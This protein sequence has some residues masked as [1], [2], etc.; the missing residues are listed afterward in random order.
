MR[1]ILKFGGDAVK[2]Q[3]KQKKAL[4][5]FLK[6]HKNEQL[7]IEEIAEKMPEEL[8]KSTLYRLMGQMTEQGQVMR[9]RGGDQKIIRYQL[10]SEED[11][12]GQHFHMQCT[13]CGTL[14]HLHCDFMEQLGCHMG[15]HHQFT[16]DPAQTILYGTCRQC[17]KGE[18]L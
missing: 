5:G 14:F 17:A 13:S 1:V 11:G 18:K 2:Y 16:I 8:G 15:E 7:T 6:E 12:C 4:L 3:T 10:V 9:F